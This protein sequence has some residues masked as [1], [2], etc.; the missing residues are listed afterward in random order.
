VF[1][2]KDKPLV[3]ITHEEFPN[4][5]KELRQ[6]R[7]M[8]QKELAKQVHVSQQTISAIENGRMD[9]SLK[10]LATIAAVLG[11]ALLIGAFWKK[12]SGNKE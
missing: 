7:L 8:T 10:L 11:V 4:Q 6:K 9:P 5:L 3:E 2:L 1:F 12:G